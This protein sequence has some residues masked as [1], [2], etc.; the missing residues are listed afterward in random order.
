MT[1]EAG[2]V[3]SIEVAGEIEGPFLNEANTEY[4]A[5]HEPPRE[6]FAQMLAKLEWV[7]IE[8]RLTYQR[9]GA[10]STRR[11]RAERR[12]RLQI[13]GENFRRPA[14]EL[15]ESSEIN[16]PDLAAIVRGRSDGSAGASSRDEQ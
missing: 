10:F 3:R 5:G 6:R 4:L 16:R 9:R 11:S 8:L 15:W 7:V 2:D 14:I 12:L 13:H 1:V